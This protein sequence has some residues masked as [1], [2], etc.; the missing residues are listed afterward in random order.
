[1]TYLT[2]LYR[3]F[4]EG[5]TGKTAANSP[6]KF[7]WVD[8]KR[9]LLATKDAISAKRIGI[10]AAGIAY[11]ATLAFFPLMAA[12]VGIASFIINDDQLHDI[13]TGIEGFLPADIASLIS[14]QLATALQDRASSLFIIIFGILLSLFS[15][16]GAITNLL[17]AANVSY[18]V[19]E[20][21][22]FI[23][24][25]LASLAIMAS[26]AVTG[27]LIIGLLLLNEPL[28]AA[29]GI[30]DP[31]IT[32]VSI[33]RWPIIA[34]IVTVSLAFFYRY[35]PNRNNPKWQWVTWGSVIAAVV[36]LIGTAA[37][38]VYARYFANFSESYSVF[39]GIIV[40]M[41]W[42]NLSAFIVLLGAEINYRLEQRTRARTT[43]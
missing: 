8:W 42:L 30:P 27:I 17:S 28:L 16:S 32:T 18:E 3:G 13:L 25:R 34:L 43:T 39:A 23:R 12:T 6:L 10:L 29:I 14:T 21:R 2:E 20:T 7:R 22:T 31:V 41:T 5:Y 4:M 9:A 24:L 37:F 26:G 19:K 40:L 15:I 1:M 36:W 33:I 38:F 11:F 35:G